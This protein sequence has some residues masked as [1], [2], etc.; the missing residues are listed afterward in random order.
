MYLLIHEKRADQT[1]RPFYLH[2]IMYLLIHIKYHYMSALL[3]H[4]HS[5]MYL[6]IR[7]LGCITRSF[8]WTF[9]FHNVSINSQFHFIIKNHVNKFTF[10]NVSINSCLLYRLVNS[11]HPY[12][13]S[14]M[15]LLIPTGVTIITNLAIFTFHNVSIN[16]IKS[17]QC[18][19]NKGI[20][21][22]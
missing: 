6:L 1:G 14:I 11:V 12:L 19:R 7:R 4:L 15:Y 20:Y 5:I 3:S 18:N 17:N 2:S 21:I 16:S 13:H 22:P 10:H 9:T 8:T